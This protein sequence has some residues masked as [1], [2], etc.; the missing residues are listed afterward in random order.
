MPN[1]KLT[2]PNDLGSAAFEKVVEELNGAT[3]QQSSPVVA[4]SGAAVAESVLFMAGEDTLLRDIALF[5]VANVA[6]TSLRTVTIQRY[7]VGVAALNLFQKTINALGGLV[8]GTPLR[9]VG[10]SGAGTSLSSQELLR[11]DVVTY[12]VSAGG[13]GA[14]ESEA[15]L[16]GIVLF[17]RPVKFTLNMRPSATT[18]KSI[19][20]SPL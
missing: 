2:L 7:R 14:G 5:N 11:N 20:A 12:T 13:G 9:L 19:Q 10:A 6:S 3:T 17:Y 18:T 8:A 16:G 1:N 4:T 15:L